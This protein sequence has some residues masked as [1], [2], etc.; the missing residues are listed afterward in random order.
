MAR[1]GMRSTN[2][3]GVLV[4]AVLVD[5]GAESLFPLLLQPAAMQTAAKR[6]RQACGT[7]DVLTLAP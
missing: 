5:A 1:S 7:D 4:H 2:F 6:A 3:R